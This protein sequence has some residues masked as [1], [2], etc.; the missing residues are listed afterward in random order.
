VSKLVLFPKKIVK[1][2]HFNL[3]AVQKGTYKAEVGVGA[4]AEKIVSASQH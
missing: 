1:T 3:K 2:L 4:G